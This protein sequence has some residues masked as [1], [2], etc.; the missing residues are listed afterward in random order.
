MLSRAWVY[1]YRQLELVCNRARSRRIS[2][3]RSLK[4][5]LHNN[6]VTKWLSERETL[7]TAQCLSGTNVIV[8]AQRQMG[9]PVSD[10]YIFSRYKLRDDSAVLKLRVC[11]MRGEETKTLR[12]AE[13]KGGKFTWESSTLICLTITNSSVYRIKVV[14]L[15]MMRSFFGFM[16]DV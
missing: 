9:L 1:R 6:A 2:S 11:Y 15:K 16:Y 4:R 3:R 10:S 13:R 7:Y 14:T 12:S 5:R 8:A